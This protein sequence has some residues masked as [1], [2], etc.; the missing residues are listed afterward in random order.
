MPITCP[1][2]TR[3]YVPVDHKYI[4]PSCG[5]ATPKD[6]IE[7]SLW[8]RVM[9]AISSMDAKAGLPGA[10]HLNSA[11][12]RWRLRNARAMFSYRRR[13]RARME[14]HLEK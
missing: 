7:E 12:R 14:L 5:A 1:F 6:L 4:C 9:R 11:T 2:C 3:S 13:S 8:L 10:I